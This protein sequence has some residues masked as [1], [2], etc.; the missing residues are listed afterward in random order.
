MNVL[1][2][3]EIEIRKIYKKLDKKVAA[4]V[5]AYFKEFA[6]NEKANRKRVEQGTMTADAFQRWRE[7]QL[8]FS[9]WSKAMQSD[10]LD[11]IDR[12]SETAYDLSEENIEEA[13]AE[14]S[15]AGL[16]MIATAIIGM[17]EFNKATTEAL[18]DMGITYTVTGKLKRGTIKPTVKNTKVRR[19]MYNRAMMAK[20]K[21][22][23][24]SLLPKPSEATLRK[25][26]REG[27]KRWNRSRLNAAIITGVRKGESIPKISKRLR[28]VTNMDKA[29]A[30]RNGRTMVNSSR[31]MGVYQRGKDIEALGFLVTKTWLTARDSRV[32]DLHKAM[33]GEEVNLTDYF[34]NGLLYPADPDGEP[35]EVYNC[36]CAMLLNLNGSGMTESEAEEVLGL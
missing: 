16:A 13:Y 6:E 33:E 12:A 32:R 8:I 17:K 29:Q 19:T 26:R 14:G 28:N 20:I 2:E 35:A 1:Q 7:Q 11:A 27:L 25:I 24:P 18:R 31:N 30:I 5:A 15:K 34:S 3:T 36:R 21:V 22:T 9:Q 10:I 4:I 23:N